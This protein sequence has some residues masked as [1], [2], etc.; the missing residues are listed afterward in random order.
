MI[1]SGILE[2]VVCDLSTSSVQINGFKEH[3]S[4]PSQCHLCAWLM[5][6]LR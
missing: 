1:R 5:L 6:L 3:G 4:T 2:S